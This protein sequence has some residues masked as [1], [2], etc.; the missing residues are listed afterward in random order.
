MNII[1]IRNDIPLPARARKDRAPKD[2][3]YPVA[4]LNVGQSFWVKL[5]KASLYAHAL[6]VAK[7][8]GRKFVV[9]EEGE[10]AR[11]WRKA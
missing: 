4:E 5:T 7:T 2:P 8:T 10:G 3:K 11:I 9:R 6:K 1:E